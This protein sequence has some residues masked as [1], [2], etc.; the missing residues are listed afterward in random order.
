MLNMLKM[1]Q[2]QL[3]SATSLSTAQQQQTS[4]FHT[5]TN[6]VLLRSKRKPKKHIYKLA[7]WMRKTGAR[8]Q[9]KVKKQVR[10]NMNRSI[11][12]QLLAEHN[13]PL[14]NVGYSLPDSMREANPFFSRN[15][16]MSKNMTPDIDPTIM[17]PKDKGIDADMKLVED[18]IRAYNAKNALARE[19]AKLERMTDEELAKEEDSSIPSLAENRLWQY[20][21]D[22]GMEDV[23]EVGT[24]DDIIGALQFTYNELIGV[25]KELLRREEDTVPRDDV[26]I[27]LLNEKLRVARLHKLEPISLLDVPLKENRFAKFLEES[28]EKPKEEVMG[29]F[30]HEYMEKFSWEDL[31]DYVSRLDEDLQY[32]YLSSI[33]PL[34]VRSVAEG[35]FV[36]EITGGV[37]SG[38]ESDEDLF[39]EL[40]DMKEVAGEIGLEWNDEFTDAFYKFN[41]MLQQFEYEML[42]DSKGYKDVI[43]NL[44][45]NVVPAHMREKMWQMHVQN[46][47]YWTGERLGRT[48]SISRDEAWMHIIAREQREAKKLGL[49]YNPYKVEKIFEKL[50]REDRIQQVK[51]SNPAT[52]R[53][54]KR[55]LQ[56]NKIPFG[57]TLS[58]E[59]A[60][61]MFLE[62]TAKNMP[63][64]GG[65][66]ELPDWAKLPFQEANTLVDKK[67]QPLKELDRME[68]LANLGTDVPAV[69]YAIVG[70]SDKEI[71]ANKRTLMIKQVDGTLREMS[72]LEKE[73]AFRKGSIKK[74][75]MGLGGKARR[76][77]AFRERRF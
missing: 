66:D 33:A 20:M 14:R 70:A 4:N 53:K 25:L 21:L 50:I 23:S 17:T 63:S 11:L 71:P 19:K 31:I 32:E 37:V 77:R 10:P 68:N 27:G 43:K 60:Y 45:M 74:S 67:D 62:E 47:R 75:R 30:Y 72:E 26:K 65:D 64:G 8:R 16:G 1:K 69:P 56:T 34:L 58:E 7:R 22:R 9:I 57:A 3:I 12:G 73:I 49:P 35:E 61:K 5:T 44:N 28:R 59:E 24:E 40:K 18:L 36:N 55:M 52:L 6:S 13:I 46:P 51:E 15:I 41:H 29:L 38:V 76:R 48:F 2:Q 39:Q 54:K 42:P